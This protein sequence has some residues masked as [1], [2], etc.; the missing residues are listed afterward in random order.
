MPSDLYFEIQFM[1]A[2]LYPLKWQKH[3]IILFNVDRIEAKLKS[4][5][6]LIRNS[7]NKNSIR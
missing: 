6:E 7:I 3:I 5:L 1:K 4:I 2:F